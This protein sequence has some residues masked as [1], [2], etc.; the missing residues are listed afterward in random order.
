MEVLD[1]LKESGFRVN[2]NVKLCPDI[3]EVTGFIED[4]NEKRDDLDYDIDGVVVKINSLKQQAMLG[5]TARTPRLG[6]GLQIS[7][8]ARDDCCKR[9]HCSDRQDRRSYACALLEPVELAGSTVSRATLH[10]EDIIKNRKI[11]A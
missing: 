5:A 7:C 8:K 6:S 3:D 10:N 4:W 9:Y 11:S 1:F 2:P